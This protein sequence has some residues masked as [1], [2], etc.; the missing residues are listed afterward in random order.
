MSRKRIGLSLL[1]L[2]S[3]ALVPYL[4][5]AA[6]TVTGEILGHECAHHGKVC[7]ST[8]L[9]PH[10]ALEPDFV[11]V[12]GDGYYFL[13]NLPRDTKVRYVLETMT[14]KGNVDDK[15][16]SIIVDELYKGEG[17]TDLIW[18][19]KEQAKLLLFDTEN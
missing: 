2:T 14:I 10:L 6:K 13:P 4:A 7:P 18:S 1:A 5:F 16:N 12:V 15:Y 11:L 3:F 17:T 9:D 8:K 19:K